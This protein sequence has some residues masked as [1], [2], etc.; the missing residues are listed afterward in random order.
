MD[1][2]VE[3]VIDCGF[4]PRQARFLVTVLLHAGVCIARQYCDFAHIAYG[5]QMHDFFRGLV[6]RRYARIYPCPDRRGHLYHVHTT[7][8]Y[9]AIG[10]P[11][12]R[13]RRIGSLGRAAERLMLLDA[14]LKAPDISWCGS[15]DDQRTLL[16]THADL[17]DVMGPLPPLDEVL[18]TRR[19]H[20]GGRPPIG[21]RERD[22]AV[23]FLYLATTPM[24]ALFR[25]ILRQ[26]V[27]LLRALPR[28]TIR[29]VFPPQL[30]AAERAYRAVFHHELSEAIVAANAPLE[31]VVLTHRYHALAQLVGTA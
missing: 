7:R 3:A 21:V 28:W 29:L 18:Q 19:G 5:Q 14:I 10:D 26:H 11:R 17:G 2:R 30:D 13:H 4:T 25:M 23:V 24:P 8:L 1:A 12:H 15:V 9:R 16:L 27:A 6:E 22:D 31:C 20:G